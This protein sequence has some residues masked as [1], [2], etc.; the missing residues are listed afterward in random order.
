MAPD[1]SAGWKHFAMRLLLAWAVLFAITF[2]E[3]SQMAFLWWNVD[4]YSFIL[5]V[6]P[7]V[8]WL[9]WMRRDELARLGPVTH[10]RLS[11]Y[12]DGGVS[13][14]RLC[15]RIAQEAAAS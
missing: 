5:L 6:P 8:A 9:V 7:I 10:V 2:T 14:L 3:W 1:R 12:P 11:I 4:T 13:R 15:G